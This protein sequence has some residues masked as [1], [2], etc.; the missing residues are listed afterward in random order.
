MGEKSPIFSCFCP[1][2]YNFHKKSSDFSL[3]LGI[4]KS[5]AAWY[6]NRGNFNGPVAGD[7]ARISRSDLYMQIFLLNAT[8]WPIHPHFPKH[9]P[10]PPT[11]RARP[12]RSDS[13]DRLLHMLRP[14]L[15]ASP[16]PSLPHTFLPHHSKPI[17]PAPPRI[18]KYPRADE[19]RARGAQLDN[20][21]YI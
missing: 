15:N 20:L 5:C 8:I 1:V 18:S 21:N 13:P 14:T 12:R 2:L 19:F 4:D 9:P 7:S 3:K 6:N 10:T 11:P 17:L 16:C